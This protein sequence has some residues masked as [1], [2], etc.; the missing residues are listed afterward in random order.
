M[1]SLAHQ[2][3]LSLRGV[4]QEERVTLDCEGLMIVIMMVISAPEFP[5]RASRSLPK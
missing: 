2:G 4:G 5:S 1:L 3:S